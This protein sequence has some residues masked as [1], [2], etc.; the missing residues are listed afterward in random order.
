MRGGGSSRIPPAATC[1]AKTGAGVRRKV[2]AIWALRFQPSH[3]PLSHP[4]GFVQLELNSIWWLT[5]FSREMARGAGWEVPRGTP[6]HSVSSACHPWFSDW[7]NP[8]SI[9]RLSV[10]Q[11]L[12]IQPPQSLHWGLPSP[13]SHVP[14]CTLSDHYCNPCH[15]HY[16]WAQFFVCWAVFPAGLLAKRESRLSSYTLS[17]FALSS[18][19]QHWAASQA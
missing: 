6:G 8:C 18:L 1:S 10:N 19:P 5:S 2:L 16:L 9:L 13:P 17:V 14:H 11:P 4:A 12:F 7:M 15:S 3:T